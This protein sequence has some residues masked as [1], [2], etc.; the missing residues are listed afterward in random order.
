[1]DIPH[2]AISQWRPERR[3]AAV[4]VEFLVAPEKFGTAGAALVDTLGVGVH[5][6]AG[7]GTLG[8]RLPKHVVLLRG[9][10]LPP[11]VVGLPDGGSRRIRSGARRGR[12]DGIGGL[13]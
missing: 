4:G 10:L 1:M 9:Q 6:L 8:P 7:I 11:L 13:V 2:N 5:V 12:G 3:P